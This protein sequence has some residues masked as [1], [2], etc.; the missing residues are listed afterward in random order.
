MVL[1]AYKVNT[2]RKGKT[3]A[4][5]DQSPGNPSGQLHGWAHQSQMSPPR[6]PSELKTV[7][8]DGE[9]KWLA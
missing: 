8:Q 3:L 1:E 5:T 4:Q 6:K 9:Q 7:T 2:S